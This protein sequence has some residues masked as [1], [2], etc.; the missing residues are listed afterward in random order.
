LKKA[1][2]ISVQKFDYI[3]I[4]AGSA[5]C[6]LAN[7]LSADPAVTV[8]MIEAGGGNT[9]P[10]VK[11]PAGV[12]GLY[13]N[14]KFD[15]IFQGVPQTHLNNREITINRGKG[16]GGSSS[17]NGMVYIRGNRNDYD[18]WE[19]LGCKG[20]SYADV[21]PL[22]KKLEFN[23]IE[24]S[25]DYHGFEGELKVVKPRDH[26]P[27]ADIFVA[28]GV[29]AG[30]PENNDFNA[31]SQFGLGIYNL[32]QEKGER[33]SSYSAFVKPVLERT[34]LTLLKQTEVLSLQFD[35]KRVTGV[36]T[37]RDGKPMTIACQREVILSAGA[38]ASP[39]LLLASG[40]GDKNDLKSLGI[41]CRQ[42]IPGVGR[43][44]Q[45][46]IDGMVTVRS[47]SAKSVGV[48]P[49]SL[50]QLIASPFKYLWYRMGWWTTNYTEAGGFAKTRFALTAEPGSIDADPDIQFHFTPIYRSH[51]GKRFE[52]GH[53]YSVFTCVLRPLSIGNVKL[54]NDG[55]H[56]NALIDHNFFAEERDQKIL[57]EGIKKA[58][59]ILA[60][61]KFDSIRG[62][63]MAPG[64]DVQTDQQIL[65]YLRKTALTVY[66]P[67]GTC[68]M[69][70]D[71]MA[72]VNPDSLKVRG[73]NN[74]RV[75]DA[76]IMPR[77]VSG[78][79]ATPTMMIA[80]KGAEM[81]LS[82]Q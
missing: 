79:T 26:N 2:L 32:K 20:W 44:L 61:E 9:S 27:L 62:K 14:K 4:G 8:C 3:I 49:G 28:A 39:R 42:H 21:L 55:T 36:F 46:H 29:D 64:D 69:G 25:A 51:R 19:K 11:I 74:L 30:L 54:A 50:P 53:G 16:L 40:I 48:S 1:E 76:S 80:E 60:S 43:N 82:E 12:F 70:I 78:N 7:R 57:I 67:V 6:V 77:L 68:K 22:F 47:Q 24:Q 63:E 81:I 71:D 35:G 56:K 18:N 31:E 33:V 45:D 66:H 13:G 73:F 65:D 58:R 37:E 59:E 38:I 41:V 52:F 72:V 75:I 5:G 10:L 15:W 34:N 23:K 17:I